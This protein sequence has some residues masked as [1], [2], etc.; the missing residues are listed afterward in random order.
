MNGVTTYYVLDLAGGLTQVLAERTGG[1]T[2]T[3]LYGNG[4][5]AQFD[6]ADFD[7]FLGDAL[8]SV[9]QLAD[10]AGAVTLARRYE[11]FGDVLTSVGTGAT[12]YAFVAE[13]F[14]AAT[15]LLYLRARFMQPYLNQFIQPDPMIPQFEDPRTL[16]RYPYANN[17]PINHTDPSGLRPCRAAAAWFENLLYLGFLFTMPADPCDQNLPRVD[18]PSQIPPMAQQVNPTGTPTPPGIPTIG[19]NGTQI[20]DIVCT[21]T[22][23]ASQTQAAARASATPT[24]ARSPTP[25]IP[26][27]LFRAIGETELEVVLA[28]G[29]YGHSPSEGGKYFALTEDGARKFA[30]TPFNRGRQMTIT[31]ITIPYAFTAR[32]FPFNDWGGAGPS[33]HFGEDDLD[34]LYRVMSSIVILGPP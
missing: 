6:G 14:D 30:K 34:D 22:A 23:A 21:V 13:N 25:G 3:Y 10:E 18:V 8:G 27:P 1:V 12:S 15:G 20:A 32:G 16:N 4:R 11:P 2:T 17:D 29:N 31:S 5:I 33:I 9:R 7:Y 28:L 26:V 19:F 24:A